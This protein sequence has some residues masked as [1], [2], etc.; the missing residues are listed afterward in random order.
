MTNGTR[1]PFKT[2]YLPIQRC[3]SKRKTKFWSGLIIFIFSKHLINLVFTIAEVFCGQEMILEFIL[4]F[5][6]S[7]LPLVLSSNWS[8]GWSLALNCQIDQICWHRLLLWWDIIS[9]VSEKTAFYCNKSE[10]NYHYCKYNQQ[11][12]QQKNIVLV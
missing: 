2:Q 11:Y 5:K 6:N 8:I 12:C 9:S 1:K 4:N 10:Y 7:I 3:Y